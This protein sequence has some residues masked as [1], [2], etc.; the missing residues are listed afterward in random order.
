MSTSVWVR[1]RK[2]DRALAGRK[3]STGFDGGEEMQT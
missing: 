3:A 1:G 2:P